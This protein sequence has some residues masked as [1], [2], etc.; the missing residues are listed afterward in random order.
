MSVLLTVYRVGRCPRPAGS[1]ADSDGEGVDDL[2]LWSS[3][4]IAVMY[5]GFIV[6]CGTCWAGFRSSGTWCRSTPSSWR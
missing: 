6:T 4:V 1:T 3:A 2:Y 5:F